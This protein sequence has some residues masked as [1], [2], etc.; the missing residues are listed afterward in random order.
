M[1]GLVDNKSNVFEYVSWLNYRIWRYTNQYL[2]STF[3]RQKLK[4]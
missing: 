4:K 3:K 2:Q 1:V